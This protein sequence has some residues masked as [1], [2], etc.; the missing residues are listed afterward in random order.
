MTSEYSTETS[1]FAHRPGLI[2]SGGQSG[3][4]F[5]GL[6]GARA[7]GIATSGWAP[8]DFRTEYG[9]NPF[10]GSHF[11]LREHVS[12]EYPPRTAANVE[13]GDATL[14]VVH[15]TAPERGSALTEKLC[16]MLQK[17]VYVIKC[18][19]TPRDLPI[20]IYCCKEWL[21]KC[22]EKGILITVLNVAGNR[23]SVSPGIENWTKRLIMGVFDA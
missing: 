22:P 6:L 13:W 15:S 14:I 4:D 5:G 20:Q 9:T 10:L 21:Q 11:N 16:R 18:A 1:G 23:E 19:L 8:K 17:P 3:A 7:C 12:R 2:V